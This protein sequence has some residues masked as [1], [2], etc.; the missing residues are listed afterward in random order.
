[1]ILTFEPSSS[2][3]D[4]SQE[5]VDCAHKSISISVMNKIRWSLRKDQAGC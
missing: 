5:N 2:P 1:M 4:P 3:F